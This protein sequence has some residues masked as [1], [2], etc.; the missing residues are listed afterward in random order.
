MEFVKTIFFGLV[1]IAGG[2]ITMNLLKPY[3]TFL[4]EAIRVTGTVTRVE[5]R[6]I[7]VEE[8]DK[9]TDTLLYQGP[10][11]VYVPIVSFEFNQEKREIDGPASEIRDVLIGEEYVVGVS[12]HNTTDAHIIIPEY[13]ALP[14][15]LRVLGYIFIVIGICPF[16]FTL[17]RHI[18]THN[19]PA[20]IQQAARQAQTERY[21]APSINTPD[22]FGETPLLKA[23]KKGYA[24]E[25]KN[26][27]DQGANVNFVNNFNESILLIAVRKN[28]AELVKLLLEAGADANY[29]NTFGKSILKIAEERGCSAEIIELLK[30]AG[31]KE[32]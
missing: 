8:R 22:K 25:A 11:T 15:V 10:R 20:A 2:I 6:V 1:F 7:Q 9:D 18:I 27:I 16:L 21:D 4:K 3:E 23:V 17:T 24:Q 31:A 29:K 30:S 26:L 14:K 13:E 5:E 12:P 28:R 19:Q 32:E